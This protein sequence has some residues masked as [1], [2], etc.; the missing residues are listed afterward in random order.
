MAGQV[1]NEDGRAFLHLLASLPPGTFERRFSE[2]S[3]RLRLD[4]QLNPAELKLLCGAAYQAALCN[5]ALNGLGGCGGQI[6]P[7]N[8]RNRTA[9]ERAFLGARDAFYA[10]SGWQSLP[11]CERGAIDRIFLRVAVTDDNLAW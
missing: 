5:I 10:S 9:L 4:T 11:E 1:M 3:L 2:I 6:K 8:E 7:S